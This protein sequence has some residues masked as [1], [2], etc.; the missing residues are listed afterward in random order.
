MSQP[1]SPLRGSMS[2]SHFH[3]GLAPGLTA[4]PPLRGCLIGFRAFLFHRKV[5][6]PI[7]TQSLKASSTENLTALRFS[8][9]LLRLHVHRIVRRRWFVI[10]A[11]LILVGDGVGGWRRN[12]YGSHD[13]GIVADL[14][15]AGQG[16]QHRR[17]NIFS[18]HVQTVRSREERRQWKILLAYWALRSSCSDRTTTTA[19]ISG[20]M[21]QKM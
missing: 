15:V 2:Y 20:W 16:L 12:N 9:S 17:L 21:L 8:S 18:P 11:V 3:P 7:V 1:L 4:L 19:L 14:Y 10:L 6:M 13:M 5:T